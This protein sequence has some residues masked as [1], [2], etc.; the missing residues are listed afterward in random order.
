MNL[1]RLKTQLILHFPFFGA[2]LHNFK[3]VVTPDVPTAA[4]DRVGNVYFN[5]EFM[6][7]HTEAEQLFILCHEV[8]HGAFLHAAR[9]GEMQKQYHMLG[10]IAADFLVNYPLKEMGLTPPKGALLDS[11]YTPDKW[12]V[13]S[14]VKELMEDAKKMEAAFAASGTG[15]DIDSEGKGGKEGNEKDGEGEKTFEQNVKQSLQAAIMSSKEAGNMSAS[16]QRMIED[17]LKPKVNWRTELYDWFNVKIR[18]ERH[19]H[20]PNKRSSWRGIY[21]PI[22]ETVGCGHIGIAVD[23]SGSI[24]EHELQVFMSEL[25]YIFETCKPSKVTVA[26]FHDCIAKVEVFT[27]MPIK[28]STPG[29]GG[30]NFASAFNYFNDDVEEEIQGLVFMTDT[31]GTWPEEPLYSTVILSTTENVTTPFGTLVYADMSK[32]D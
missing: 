14:L 13:E 25:N 9:I 21:N 16:L 30:T 26:Y 20:K 31:Y 19:W 8:M 10:N 17:L 22:K 18:G 24:G 2:L 3:F 6:D 1:Q 7:K 5:E 32:E 28:L 23:V 12:T 27:E 11:K 15:Q 4:I 29:G